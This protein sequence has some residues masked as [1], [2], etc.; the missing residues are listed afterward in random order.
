MAE[1]HVKGSSKQKAVATGKGSLA[2]NAAKYA[3]VTVYQFVTYAD[4]KATLRETT[5][6]SR[7]PYP[8]LETF[9]TSEAEFFV[10]RENDVAVLE[11]QLNKY[12]VI[13]VIAASGAGKSSLVHAGLIPTLAK[14]EA[15]I[16]DVFAFKPGQETIY[17]LAR[18]MSGV[19]AEAK[20]RKGQ[21]DEIDAT[22]ADLRQTPGR[23]RRY[24]ENIASRRAHMAT[25]K[26]HNILIFV[27]QWEELYTQE[28][29]KDRDILIRELMDVAERGL[30]KV[31][32]TMRI[33]F[34]D[35]LVS[36]S[37]DFYN[38]LEPAIRILRPLSETGR[39]AAIEKPAEIAGLGIPKELTSRLLADLGKDE[40]TLPYLQ[41]GLRQLW[42]K[43]DKET[44]SLTT[45]TYDRMQG[46]NGAIGIHADD[47]FQKLQRKEPELAFLAQRVLPRLANVS[48]TGA[49][50]SRRLP[51]ADFD[52]PARVLFRKLA[53]P[54]SRLITLSS[55]TDDVTET[56][57]VA[58]VAHEA[59]LDDW[60]TLSRWISER[61]DFFR[62]RNKL[63]ADAKTWLENHSRHD[64]LIP[65][66][67]QL[68]D[69]ADLRNDAL[70]GE[71][72]NDLKDY[73]NISFWKNR[74]R[75]WI[76]S[77]AFATILL[78]TIGVA[79]YFASLTKELS[80]S[81]KVLANQEKQL[82]ERATELEQTIQQVN[83]A[84]QQAQKNLNE[85]RT[86]QVR[87]V[88]A[89]TLLNAK[90]NPVGTREQLIE[91]LPYI[92]EIAN[93]DLKPLVAKAFRE[94]L[95]YD[96]EI[97]RLQIDAERSLFSPGGEFL[98][99]TTRST[100]IVQLWDSQTG[101]V[102]WS[103]E[104]NGQRI[105]EIEFSKDGSLVGFSSLNGWIQ[106]ISTK[107]GA[108]IGNWKNSI[109]S[110]KFFGFSPNGKQ[111]LA[112]SANGSLD[113]RSIEN[114][115]VIVLLKQGAED[116]FNADFSDDGHFILASDGVDNL[117][118]WNAL[119]GQPVSEL[120]FKKEGLISDAWEYEL[121]HSLFLPSGKGILV[122]SGNEAVVWDHLSEKVKVKLDAP[123]ELIGTAGFLPNGKLIYL[124]FADN[125]VRAFDTSTGSELAGFFEHGEVIEVTSASSEIQTVYDISVFPDGN[126]VVSVASDGTA[127]VWHALT[128]IEKSVNRGH[129]HVVFDVDVSA[130]NSRVL[131][132]SSDKTVRVWYAREYLEQLLDIRGV[133]SYLYDA[134][135]SPSD[136]KYALLYRDGKIVI[137]GLSSG[138][139]THLSGC[140]PHRPR[141]AAFLSKTILASA[142]AS[143]VCVWDLEKPGEF[144][145]YKYN[146][147]DTLYKTEL[148][149]L[150]IENG[151][152]SVIRVFGTDCCLD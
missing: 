100:G 42:E 149:I 28:N 90:D 96:N 52:E 33:D 35:D 40:G 137:G 19:L 87:R 131:T 32:L 26:S 92:E 146:S 148:G 65:E 70:E 64:L 16:W 74:S 62:L 138:L 152:M 117:K 50:T 112:A 37:T 72:S 3:S 10:G 141:T 86:N 77:G 151:S 97:L 2:I 116:L 108:N 56:E 47:V 55:A 39:R 12:D 7:C 4:D 34:M 103:K 58:E 129:E 143:Y 83:A 130:D 107:D 89:S 41:F 49:I 11:A 48:E 132:T 46:L 122:Y 82:R 45:E 57:I 9:R 93:P 67:K 88:V 53:E 43:R 133:N 24:I 20:T 94:V 22:V 136:S 71:I 61:K 125:S 31:I 145:K 13:G 124:S 142:G 106:I 54:D 1:N 59:L 91:I 85:A 60:K 36:K 150:G 111:F 6:P 18:S 81:N 126:S 123:Q 118:V 23:L 99:T 79:T 102:I 63:E 120:S 80:D 135:S 104:G 78:F 38:V 98:L 128:G 8:G 51:F 29:D 76:R 14:R 109:G 27:D 110:A 101:Q 121:S 5:D 73:L 21:F 127:R 15:E 140:H 17:G 134:I 25:G 66:G 113:L 75:R 147:L 119:N 114:D 69:A 139:E 105:P 68:L 95:R 44:N 115:G 144:E 84:K 30:A